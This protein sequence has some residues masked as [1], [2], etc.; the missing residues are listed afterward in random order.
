MGNLGEDDVD[1]FVDPN[2]PAE[3][4]SKESSRKSSGIHIAD[5]DDPAFGL[6]THDPETGRKYSSVE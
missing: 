6:P 2:A 3:P 1:D 4:E 5:P